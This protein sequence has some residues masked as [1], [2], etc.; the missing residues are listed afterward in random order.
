LT[1]AVKAVAAELRRVGVADYS[2]FIRCEYFANIQDI[3]NSSVELIFGPGR[4][5]TAG[6]RCSNSIGTPR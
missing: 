6:G 3:A 2:A 1:D 4:S 5:P